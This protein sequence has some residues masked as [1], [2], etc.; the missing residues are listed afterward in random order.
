VHLSSGAVCS[1]KA[2]VFFRD[3]NDIPRW[4]DEP[5]GDTCP[6]GRAESIPVPVCGSRPKSYSYFETVS[7]LPHI[8]S[9][10]IFEKLGDELSFYFYKVRWIAS[11]RG[12]LLT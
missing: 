9:L 4:N 2:E 11:L 7:N 5:E 6:T 12:E 10:M 1:K 8:I 3:T